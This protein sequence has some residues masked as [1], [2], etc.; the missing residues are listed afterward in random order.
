M[1]IWNLLLS[2]TDYRDKESL[3]KKAARLKNPRFFLDSWEKRGHRANSQD[4]RDKKVNAGVKAYQSRQLGRKTRVAHD[5]SLKDQSEWMTLRVKNSRGRSHEGEYTVWWDFPQGAWANC[6]SKPE[7]KNLFLLLTGKGGKKS[8]FEIVQSFLL[9]L[10]RPALG[11]TI[12]FY[13]RGE[14]KT[15]KYL[16]SSQP[17]GPGSLKDWDKI[18]GL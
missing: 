17:R 9:F 15:E 16:R 7:R 18:M 1:A 14:E 8:H 10:T 12:L 2:D 11:E 4:Y 3:R 13:L 5:E 6:H